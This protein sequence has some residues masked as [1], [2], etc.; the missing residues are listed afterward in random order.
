M[1]L[2]VLLIL[3]NLFAFQT[4]D[5]YA[6][7]AQGRDHDARPLVKEQQ[8][9]EAAPDAA[10][11]SQDG[12]SGREAPEATP[13]I[14]STPF[15]RGLPAAPPVESTGEAET[16]VSGDATTAQTSD[17]LTPPSVTIPGPGVIPL[18]APLPLPP[19]STDTAAEQVVE[20]SVKQGVIIDSRAATAANPH[21]DGNAVGNPER[22]GT[23]QL[24]LPKDAFTEQELTA[25][26]L[27]LARAAWRYFT[28]NRQPTTGLVNAVNRY[29]YA[30]LWDIASAVAALVAA[31][32][33]GI[34]DRAYFEQEMGLLLQTLSQITLYNDELPNREYNTRTGQMVDI[35]SRP[36]H[37]GSGW[38]A[39]DIGRCLIW[40]KITALW[41]P[42]LADQVHQ[43]VKRWRFDRLAQNGE[44]H[45]VLH[46]GRRE[47]IRQEGRLGYEQYAAVG[48]AL[49]DLFLPGALDYDAVDWVNILGVEVPYDRRDHAYLGSEPFMLA[50]M[51]LGGIDSNFGDMVQRIYQVQKRRWEEYGLLTAISEDAVNVR[52]WFVYNC[53]Y[54]HGKPW[55]C[56]GHNGAPAPELKSISTKA[57]I[58]WSVIFP[59]D[60]SRQLREAVEGLVH[61]RYGYQAGLFENGNV[62]K[63][64]NVNTNAVILE[65]MLYKKRGGEPFLM[66]QNP[67]RHAH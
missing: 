12:A 7:A 67:P 44:M 56:V 27:Q 40:L 24:T 37:R 22:V 9:T 62:N 55:Q 15:A 65:A 49:W 6:E 57:A 64:L 35:K 66:W 48:Y 11:H 32:Q 45:G 20:T 38:S 60:Y 53:I 54:L 50:Q 39:L 51:E 46:N 31:E 33:I 42:P 17:S 29:T 25:A 19:T 18:G 52:P 61:P 63:S 30:T 36:S 43:V 1:P 28:T 13:G 26:D 59:D 47:K 3:L 4:Q 34:I 21:P 5:C 16:P 58:C 14:F 8:S 2:A 23:P 10:V 41:Y